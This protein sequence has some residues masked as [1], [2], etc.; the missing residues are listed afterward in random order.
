MRGAPGAADSGKELV[1][2][3][4]EHAYEVHPEMRLPSRRRDHAGT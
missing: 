4:L 3:P 1:Q 2:T